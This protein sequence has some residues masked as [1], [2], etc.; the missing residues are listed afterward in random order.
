MIGPYGDDYAYETIF[1]V[2]RPLFTYEDT[3]EYFAS[4]SFYMVSIPMTSF[5]SSLS[6]DELYYS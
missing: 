6:M 3:P 2:N 1:Y 5:Y 4:T